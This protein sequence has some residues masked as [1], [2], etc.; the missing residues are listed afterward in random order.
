MGVVIVLWLFLMVPWVCLLFVIVVFP[1]YT[2]LHF[3]SKK[4]DNS[5]ITPNGIH[6][7]AHT[8][9]DTVI[10]VKLNIK[11]KVKRPTLFCPA[12]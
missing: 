4:Y 2:N 11:L 5:S 1:D 6:I 7:R 8:N 10:K 9:K 12:R 3:G